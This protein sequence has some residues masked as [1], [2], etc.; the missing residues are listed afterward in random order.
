MNED[1]KLLILKVFGYE[2]IDLNAA[3]AATAM[4]E[5]T[6]YRYTD[7]PMGLLES[8][9]ECCSVEQFEEI[10]SKIQLP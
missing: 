7:N 3:D 6:S 9:V 4:S 5:M 8:F 2:P 10:K 1:V